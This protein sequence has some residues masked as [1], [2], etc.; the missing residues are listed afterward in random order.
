MTPVEYAQWLQEYMG[1]GGFKKVSWEKLKARLKEMGIANTFWT[2]WYNAKRKKQ[3]E[4]GIPS[5]A[6]IARMYEE[7]NQTE[8]AKSE[9]TRLLTTSRLAHYNNCI[10]WTDPQYCTCGKIEGVDKGK[11]V[12]VLP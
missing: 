2:A 9:E 10:Y 7:Y 5:E 11:R 6:E 3:E 12:V 4:S 1:Y 8:M